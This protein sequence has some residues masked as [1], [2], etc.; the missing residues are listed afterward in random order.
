M[1]ERRFA[2][3][4][5]IVLS[6][7]TKS[8]LRLMCSIRCSRLELKITFSRLSIFQE[9]CTSESLRNRSASDRC[10]PR[11]L[12]RLSALPIVP[13]QNQRFCSGTERSTVCSTAV[14]AWNKKRSMKQKLKDYLS[15]SVDV[16]YFYR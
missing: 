1:N 7:V 9:P 13:I 4:L 6:F 12:P 3:L 14:L 5:S 15:D 11:R 8:H 16:R 2:C 10:R